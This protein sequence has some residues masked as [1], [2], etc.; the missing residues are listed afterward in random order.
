MNNIINDI[1]QNI[2]A[3]STS[4]YSKFKKKKEQRKVIIISRPEIIP[5]KLKKEDLNKIE[6]KP[7]GKELVKFRKKLYKKINNQNLNLL[8]NNIASLKIKIKYLAPEILLLKFASGKYNIVKN[9]IT[10]LKLFESSAKV[11]EFFHLASSYYDKNYKLGFSGFQQIIFEKKK[12]FGQG[13]NEGYTE[14]ISR[15]YFGIENS[16][17]S[18]R[19]EVCMFFAKKLEEIVGKDRMET[20]YL[21]ADL[22]SLYKYLSKFDEGS[23]VATFIAILDHLFKKATY[24]NT[25]EQSEYYELLDCYLSKWFIISK[26]EELNNNIINENTFKTEIQNYINSLG[27]KTLGLENYVKQKEYCLK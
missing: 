24:I 27:N 14:L 3:L 19:Y 7:L 11:H 2:N 16:Y 8:N 22:F 15:R 10:I 17:I 1:D 21:N 26:Q 9:K 12:S 20:F 23:N 25:K 5:L 6:R 18:Y 4:T 13:L